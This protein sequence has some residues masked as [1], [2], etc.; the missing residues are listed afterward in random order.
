MDDDV[1]FMEKEEEGDPMRKGKQKMNNSD[2]DDDFN[3]E[4]KMNINDNSDSCDDVDDVNRKK[5]FVN[6]DDD[7]DDMSF[8]K[9]SNRFSKSNMNGVV[10]CV[11]MLFN[12]L[13]EAKKFYRDYGR[14]I[15]FEIIIRSTHRYS[16]GNGVSSRLYI[17]YTHC[18]DMNVVETQNVV[19]IQIAAHFGVSSTFMSLTMDIFSRFEIKK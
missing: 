12:N 19:E 10:P 6:V 13:D 4:E 5:K 16:R 14:C 1:D 17:C 3:R 7:D 8:E 18:E 9:K 15:G 11:G 2:F